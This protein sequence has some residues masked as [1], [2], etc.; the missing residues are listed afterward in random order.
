MLAPTGRDGELMCSVLEDAA[1]RC[2]VCPDML[3]LCR[4]LHEG[5]AALLIAEEGLA[6]ELRNPLAPMRTALEIMRIAP[7]N[8]S[9]REQA[10]AV[11]ERQLRQMA[12]LIDDLLDL[13]R[14]S[15]GKLELRHEP[16][17]LRGVIESAI[18]LTWP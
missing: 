16:L 17:T 4:S 6:H 15:H 9:A 14:I 13:S 2:R 10:Q 12:R 18:E 1:V 11:L 5:G 7:K 3:D 8:E